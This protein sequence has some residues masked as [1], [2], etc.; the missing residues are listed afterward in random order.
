MLPQ[1][2]LHL[3]LTWEESCGDVDLH[4]SRFTQTLDQEWAAPPRAGECNRAGL[5]RWGR[6]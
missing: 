3:E 1:G 4:S 5:A 2:A 6:A